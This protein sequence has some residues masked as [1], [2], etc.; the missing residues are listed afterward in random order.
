M[1]TRIWMHV[2][3]I[4]LA[5]LALAPVGVTAQVAGNSNQQPASIPPTS[6]APQNAPNSQAISQTGLLPVFAVDMNFDSSWVDGADVPSKSPVYSHNGVTDQ[7]QSAWD[8][9][10]AAG[11]N[12]I[13]FA[14]DSKDTHSASRLANLCIW[15]KVNNVLLIPVLENGNAGAAGTD[16]LGPLISSLRAGDG[17]NFAAYTQIAY[18][19]VAKSANLGGPHAK[20]SAE[21]PKT[22]LS[23]VDALRSAEL[24]ALQGTQI[25]ATPIMVGLSFDFELVRQGAIAGVP[26]DAAAEKKAQAALKK[27][28]APFAANAN[29]D[30]IDVAWFPRSISSGDEGHFASLMREFQSAIAEKQLILTTGFSTAF[31]TADQQNQF[32]TVTITNLWDFRLSTGGTSSRFLGVIFKQ[33]LQGTKANAPAPAGSDPSQWNWKEKA[34]QLAEMWSGGKPS[35]DLKWWLSRID[36]N[37]GL[38]SAPSDASP[39]GNFVPLPSL[40]AIQQVS[41]TFARAAQNIALPASSPMTTGNPVATTSSPTGMAISNPST[42]PPGYP[43]AAYAQTSPVPGSQ[44]PGTSSPSPY[45]QLLLTLVQQVTPQITSALIAR[46]AGRSGGSPAQYTPYAPQNAGVPPPASNYGATSQPYQPGVAPGSFTPGT[47]SSTVPSGAITI[48][49]Q[50]VTIDAAS[51]I[52]GQTVHIAVQIHNGNPSQDVS[53]L[54]AQLVDPTNPAA[55]AQNMQAGISVPHLGT[56]PLQFS[57][58][59]GQGSITPPQLSVQVLDPTGAPLASVPVPP[60]SISSTGLNSGLPSN[61][62]T[63]TSLPAGTAPNGFVQGSVA[64][65]TGATSASGANP[66]P[67]NYSPSNSTVAGTSTNTNP[68]SGSTP[69]AGTTT[70]NPGSANSNS[71]GNSASGASTG[72]NPSPGSPSPAI[73]LNIAYL[74]PVN[75]PGQSLAFLVQVVNPS[76]VPMSS[77]QAQIYV[78]GG[79]GQTISLGPL[80]PQQS[81]SAV[82]DQSAITAT[83]QTVKVVVTSQD[84]GASASASAPAHPKHTPIADPNRRGFMARGI[85]VRSAGPATYNIGPTSGPSSS[86][87][88]SSGASQPAA[89]PSSNSQ[90]GTTTPAQSGTVGS[91]TSVPAKTNG[92][93]AQGQTPGA[94]TGSTT[95]P[96]AAGSTAQPTVSTA[97]NQT[98]GSAQSTAG[99]SGPTAVAATAVPVT[100]A[101]TRAPR[102]IQ[103]AGAASGNQTSVG[104]QTPSSST[105]AQP[106]R[107]IPPPGN[108]TPRTIQ[109]TS[110]GSANPSVAGPQ[111]SSSPVPGQTARTIQPPGASPVNRGPSVAGQAYLDLSVSA[112][113]V[114]VSPSPQAGQVLV[115]ALIRNL[116]TIGSNAASV[117]FRLIIGGKQVA[118]SS[119]ITFSIQGSGTYPANWMTAVPVGQAVQVIVSVNAMGDMNPANNQAAF[120]LAAPQPV[121]ARH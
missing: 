83:N 30:V 75:V 47:A 90:I 6:P 61:S 115:T 8:L 77:V 18:F 121:Q 114:R 24:Q 48:G 117:V 86:A 35:E 102:T 29:V 78:D 37:M 97:A 84:T 27:F 10:K 110:V 38:L 42:A 21:G 54:T 94:G 62:Q 93:S 67:A 19:Q 112:T 44:T 28:V 46:M 43:V 33:G 91:Q 120:S 58:I 96:S 22:L 56:T 31:N 53:G 36:S 49:P 7:F 9:L 82:F 95:S 73:A 57:W 108:V 2:E 81:R 11:F 71:A 92:S 88:D 45:Q 40:Q 70:T 113:D 1:K 3:W 85:A 89:P 34:Q 63:A 111:A 39:G 66:L 98:T 55:S 101:S 109:P 32:L 14:L 87:S 64:P 65:A 100:R 15:A 80:L 5:I 25:Q 16:L 23:S 104:A 99:S 59:A 50:D 69:I 17:S 4:V 12:A 20:D 107:T 13:R 118:I 41:T 119:P 106:T 105:P 72:G 60:I 79:A 103:P 116:G 51:V 76:A 68:S 52:P 74:G 26:L